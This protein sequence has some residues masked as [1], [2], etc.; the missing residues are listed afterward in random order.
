[1]D[2][3]WPSHI[4]GGSGQAEDH[5]LE[6]GTPPSAFCLLLAKLEGFFKIIEKVKAFLL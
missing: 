3:T 6:P 2:G 5:H 1:M 4:M